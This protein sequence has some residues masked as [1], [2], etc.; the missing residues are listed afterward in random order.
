MTISR[1]YGRRGFFGAFAAACGAFTAA[2]FGR[3]TAPSAPPAPVMPVD[4]VA[5][6]SNWRSAW[7]KLPDDPL[8]RMKELREQAALTAK[9][10]GDAFA[11][12]DYP[13]CEFFRREQETIWHEIQ[14][15]A[16]DLEKIR[17]PP[18][19]PPA[20]YGKMH[21]TW[22]E[23]NLVDIDRLIDHET[24]QASRRKPRYNPRVRRIDRR[25]IGRPRKLS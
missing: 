20:L 12:G 6:L 17:W 8:E 25:L 24:E 11:A 7:P 10:A 5:P 4:P 2:L 13:A 18:I 1:G 21:V 23:D 19:H 22:A 3:E 16:I 15:I 14:Y 9:F